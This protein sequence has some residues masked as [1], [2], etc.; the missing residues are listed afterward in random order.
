MQPKLDRYGFLAN[1]AEWNEAVANWLAE[2]DG[3]ALT[4]AHWEIILF[5]REY[6]VRYNHL[7]N[8][9]LFGQALKKQLGPEK[10]AS[11]RWL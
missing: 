8:A 4:D 3:V 1:R 10:G 5:M 9:R 6:Y 11:G 7:P 2:S